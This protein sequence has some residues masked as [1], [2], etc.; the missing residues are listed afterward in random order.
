MLTSAQVGRY[1]CV[2]ARVVGIWEGDSEAGRV[3]HHAIHWHTACLQHWSGISQAVKLN[4]H[5]STWPLSQHQGCGLKRSDAGH[6]VGMAY[7]CQCSSMMHYE[8][9]EYC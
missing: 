9:W 4:K 3:M 1:T 8:I 7:H 5:R 6:A 2:E